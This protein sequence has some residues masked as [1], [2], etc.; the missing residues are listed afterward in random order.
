MNILYITQSSPLETG[1]GSAQRSHI[2]WNALREVG[3]VYTVVPLGSFATQTNDEENKIHS[4]SFFSKNS[5]VFFFERIIARFGK[6]LDIPFRSKRFVRQKIGWQDVKFDLVVTRYLKGAA[7]CSA[8]NLAPCYIDIDDWPIES[9]RTIQKPKC[10][11]I[12][13]N[14][15]DWAYCV[16]TDFILKRTTA[17]W[18]P[19][20]SQKELVEKYCPCEVLPNLP[21]RPRTT[22]QMSGRQQKRL[23][24][25]GLMS[26]EPNYEGVDWF[27]DHIWPAIHQKFPE[28]I[29]AIGGKGTPTQLAQKW[30]AMPG[31]EQLGFVDDLESVY[32]SALAVVTPINSGAGTCIKVLEASLRG[33]Y[34]LATPFAVRGLTAEQCAN[35]QMLVSSTA[36]DYVKKLDEILSLSEGER[37]QQQEAIAATFKNY[38]SI[39]AFN[40]SVKKLIQNG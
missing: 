12:V 2:L 13:G 8:W 26:Y 39:Q 10:W 34:I 3:T 27:L 23:L 1:H 15:F 14:F 17:A 25:I 21:M 33:R 24:T 40:S 16:W 29:Y 7:I 30:S 37:S 9:Y 22:Y 19:N 35:L 5:I 4:V 36:E 38:F 20:K 18:V 11:K 28:L 31:V 32:E 6:G